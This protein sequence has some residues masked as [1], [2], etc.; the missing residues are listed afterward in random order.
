M[1]ACRCLTT[2]LLLFPGATPARHHHP[3]PALAAT[4][5][6]AAAHPAP[7][8]R[9]DTIRPA[10]GTTHFQILVKAPRDSALRPVGTR[11]VVQT[12]SGA[13]AARTVARAIVFEYPGRKPVI[14]STASLAATLAPLYERTYKSAGL[15][16][17][18]FDGHTVR[19]TEPVPGAGQRP[20]T[21]TLPEPAFNTTDLDLVVQSLPLADGYTATLPLYDRDMGHFR[22]GT[23]RVT[24][25]KDVRTP[26][27]M[28]RAW[29][30]R[31]EEPKGSFVYLVSQ[32]DRA[33]LQLD[34]D[35]F[36][37]HTQVR[38]VAD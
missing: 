35:V 8:V 18:T 12:T 34:I 37:K 13:G 38:V 20:F 2:L 5:D 9:L 31:V 26:S 21:E 10:D 16:A 11:T 15:L 4:R 29:V 28:R 7:A 30:V 36:D 17:F 3:V 22:H 1:L 14:D 24:G 25:T 33:L 32:A 19:G 6:T 27:G 23:L